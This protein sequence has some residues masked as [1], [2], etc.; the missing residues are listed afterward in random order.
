[1]PSRAAPAP[2]PP[3]LRM[4]RIG[5]PS[6]NVV[7]TTAGRR[8]LFDS[9]YG[10]DAGRLPAALAQAGAPADALELV[11][12]THWHS[13]HV[14]G[15]AALQRRHGIPVA[16]E[17]GDAE[18]VN[19]CDR[20]ACMAEWLDQPVE[21][22][23]VDVPLRP[24]DR[25]RAGPADWEV[26]S[27]PGHTPRHLSFHQP[28]ERVLVLGDALHDDDVGWIDVALDGP[29]AIDAALRTVVSLA[30]LA[31]RVALSGHGPVMADPPRA[32]A[33]AHARY[34]RMR[35][36][37]QRAAWHAMK[38][39]LAFALMIRDGVALDE[40]DAYLVASPWLAGHAARVFATT[41]EALA[42]DLLAE[43]RRAGAVEE[44]DGRLRCRTPS[45]PP[46]PEWA[47]PAPPRGWARATGA[48]P[49]AG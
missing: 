47:R 26:L 8:V 1:M 42:A 13:D 36:D 27:T 17:A 5:Y 46:P 31:P 22:Y 35:A 34:E 18:A 41:P 40:L 39:I 15:N 4:L 25:L 24:G 45:H 48:A 33:A 16:A 38:R 12:N 6:A 37:P 11:V 14:G 44:R 32:F 3:W 9:G 2:L 30:A 21:R 20:A 28:D 49:A 10:S 29:A 43:M 19:R 7:V 23:R